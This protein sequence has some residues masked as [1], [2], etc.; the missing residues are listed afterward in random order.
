MRKHYWITIAACALHFI[1]SDL[2][3]DFAFLLL[4]NYAQVL[5]LLMIQFHTISAESFIEINE[6]YFRDFRI[7]IHFIGCL[8]IYLKPKI[9]FD[10]FILKS[11]FMKV[12]LQVQYANFM[13]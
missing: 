11:Y 1:A 8:S 3:I 7:S 10:Y 2:K 13:N 12:L 4:K 6:A 5:I 9:C